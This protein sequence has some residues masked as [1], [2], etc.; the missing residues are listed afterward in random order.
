VRG[1]PGSLD[2]LYGTGGVVSGF[3][4]TTNF[5]SFDAAGL[6]ANGNVLLAIGSQL[7]A[8]AVSV[9]RIRPDGTL[10]PS[11]GTGGFATIPNTGAFFMALFPLTTGDI[12]LCGLTQNGSPWTDEIVRLTPLGAIDTSFSPDGGIGNSIVRTD[13]QP[14]YYALDAQGRVVE[15][16]FTGNATGFLLTRRAAA[17]PLDSTFDAAFTSTVGGP[18]GPTVVQPDGDIVASYVS[19]A[20]PYGMGLVRTDSSG[21]LDSSFG[22][23]GIVPATGPGNLSAL[24][25]QTDGKLVAGGL[26]YSSSGSPMPGGFVARYLASGTIDLTF[27]AGGVTTVSPGYVT[28]I[29]LDTSDNTLAVGYPWAIGDAGTPTDDLW[30]ERVTSGGLPDVTFGNGG[31]VTT[32]VGGAGEI[33]EGEF[34]GVQSDGRIVVVAAIYK[35]QGVYDFAVARFWP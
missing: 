7:G 13:G 4:T 15:T 27:G 23:N 12:Q 5:G 3:L 6:D 9:I 33:T 16:G 25:L 21:A 19:Q 8:G 11:F 18:G 17:G 1:P 24:L 35:S 32:P 29:A 30:V 20:A 26:V 22:T 2:T 28:S 10:D 31:I 34:V 14:Y